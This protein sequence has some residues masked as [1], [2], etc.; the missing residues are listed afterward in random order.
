MV[1]RT[2]L[3]HNTEG[4][5]VRRLCAAAQTRAAEAQGVSFGMRHRV[6]TCVLLVPLL[7][8][9]RETRSTSDTATVAVSDTVPDTAAADSVA[10]DWTVRT[11]GIGPIRVGRPLAEAS[12]TLGEPLVVRARDCD[13]VTPTRTP[14]GVRFM[15]VR[16]T[17][18]R[19]E[20]DSAGVRTVD[21]AQVGDSESRV[22]ELYGTRA[23]I[24]PHKYTYPN[25]HYLVIAPPGDPVHRL[26]FET[27]DGRVTM[28][29]AGRVPSVQWAEGCS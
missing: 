13:H 11:D 22:L 21:G 26:I 12:R 5:R 27:L 8:C 7:A 23:R 14:A 4:C 6:L 29:R 16:D 17:V 25:G 28:F 20:V 9:T 18:V 24:E 19:I 3:T 15:V 1:F 2:G 10:P